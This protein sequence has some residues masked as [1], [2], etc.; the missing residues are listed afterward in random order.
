MG[1][2]KKHDNKKLTAST[3]WAVEGLIFLWVDTDQSRATWKGG[4][5]LLSQTKRGNLRCLQEITESSELFFSIENVAQ[6][7]GN[8]NPAGCFLQLKRKKS[9]P[10]AVD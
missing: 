7:T 9:Y 3:R 1:G 10:M 5:K 6:R 8:L 4:D 2:Y